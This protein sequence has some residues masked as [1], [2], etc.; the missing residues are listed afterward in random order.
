M[1][2]YTSTD[3]I[4]YTLSGLS[5]SNV[6]ISNVQILTQPNSNTCGITAVTV[7][8]NFFNNSNYTIE[9]VMQRNNVSLNQ[10]TSQSDILTWLKKEIPE[11][12]IKY[13]KNEDVNLMITEIHASLS[14]NNPIII[15]FGSPNPYN[16][17]MYD[18]HASTIYGINSIDET[19][20]I[21]NS[22]GY[23]ETI[24]IVDFLNRMSFAELDKYPSTQKNII[25]WGL[26][27]KNM[28]FIVS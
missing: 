19:I 11:K 13:H 23:E 15:F 6:E 24:S 3:L 22:Y 8:S 20:L 7:M 25:K 2:P 12:T 10:S 18:F 21:S 27:D 26:I 9:E 14:D 16:S 4:S 1:E 5:P 17:P 28:L